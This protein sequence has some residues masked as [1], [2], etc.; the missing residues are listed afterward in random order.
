MHQRG[1]AAQ[2]RHAGHCPGSA[3]RPDL[4]HV[5]GGAGERCEKLDIQ[6]YV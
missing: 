5:C 3:P 2:E 4:A 6:S 1:M